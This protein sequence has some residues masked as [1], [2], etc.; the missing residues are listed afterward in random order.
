MFLNESDEGR[1]Q[2]LSQY[3]VCRERGHEAAYALGPINICS[4]CQVRYQ[5]VLQEELTSL[6]TGVN[7]MIP[8]TNISEWEE[9]PVEVVF[10]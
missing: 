3:R 4:R 5:F 7:R 10:P 6:P 9:C 2:R 1:L 8:G